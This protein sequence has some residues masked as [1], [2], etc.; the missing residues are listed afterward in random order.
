MPG[1]AATRTK[2][3]DA[4]R[5]ELRYFIED[6]GA[7]LWDS[8]W[9]PLLDCGTLRAALQRRRRSWQVRLTARY[10]A[11]DGGPILEAG[12]G[13]GAVVAQLVSAGY[14]CVGVDS[15]TRTVATVN[16]CVPDLDIRLG[17][18]ES[19]QFDDAAFAGCWSIGVIEHSPDSYERIAAEM[20]R[21][22][23]PG[24][25]L[26]ISFPY[27][28]P[29]RRAKASV[30]RY[31][32]YDG[33]PPGEHFYQFALRP[34]HVR[35]HFEDLG[36]EYLA[37]HRHDSL[38]GLRDE[39]RLVDRAVAALQAR[40]AENRAARLLLGAWNAAAEVLLSG[41]CAHSVAVVFR[42]SQMMTAA[43]DQ[44]VREG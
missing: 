44:R 29:L 32:R 23:R 31:A 4:E 37:R 17:D 9:E 24:G 7:D 25:L 39:V 3:Y 40:G 41:V 30:G 28:N 36:F 18:L 22:V 42:K 2:R 10:L 35:R 16:E 20:A 1:E 13:I 33:A 12:C 34:E 5:R 14:S 6:A 43:S 11:P 26:F 21:V 8:Y 19:L 15:A 27:M 38:W